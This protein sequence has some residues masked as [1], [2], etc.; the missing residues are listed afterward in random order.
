MKLKKIIKYILIILS[1]VAV[2][3]IT[4]ILISFISE[5]NDIPNNYII[6]NN[7]N[8]IN[9]IKEEINTE[10]QAK[11]DENT[12]GVLKIPK[13]D[14]EAEIKEGVELDV[15]AQYIGHFRNSSL[16]DG[17]VALASHNRGNSVAHHFERIHLLKNGD[18]ILYI[19]NLGERRYTVYNTKEIDSTDWSVT[20][21]TSENIIT[22]ITCISNKPEK[23]LCVQAKAI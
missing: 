11:F 10:T 17:N 14:L 3:F 4:K 8:Q 9:D 15:L 6:E 16:W 23:R 5:K 13:I 2:L 19:T 1:L 22:L 18:E 12:I 21:E 7:T 20:L